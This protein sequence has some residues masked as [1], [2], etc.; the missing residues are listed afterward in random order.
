MWNEQIIAYC[1][2]TDFSYWSEP[3]NAVTNLAFVIA[4]LVV[5][6]RTRGL[7][8]A[9]GMA[10]VLMAV[11]V[12]SFL[13][14]THATDWAGLMDVVFILVFILLYLFAATRDFLYAPG[15]LA[16]LATVMFL[17]YA[18]GFSWAAGL[19]LPGLGANAAYFS[20][21]VLIAGYG[22]WL[23]NRPVG[24]GLLVGAGILCVSLG[25][26]MADEAVCAAFPTGTHFMWHIL[27]AVMLGWMIHIYC[28]HVADARG[29]ARR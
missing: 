6:P 29:T 24:K 21:A 12:G 11:G 18:A 8:L 22:V 20:V 2:R 5:W 13:W 10:V 16:A 23:R 19:V 4:A 27:N 28:R 14:H 3:V 7:V 1:E 9:R 15:W 26:R 25:F 17:P